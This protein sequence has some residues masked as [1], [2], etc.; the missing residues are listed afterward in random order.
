MSSTAQSPEAREDF[1]AEPVRQRLAARL[2]RHGTG[3]QALAESAAIPGLMMMRLHGCEGMV[4]AIYEPLVALVVQG[5]KRVSFGDETYRYDPQRYFVTPLELPGR[6]VVLEATPERPF[7]SLA[8][9]LDLREIATLV[10]EGVAPPPPAP[11]AG[12]RAMA[13]GAVDAPLLDAFDRLLALLD[14][15]QHAPVLAPLI[16]REITYRLLTGEAGWRLRQIAAVDSQGHQ[17]SRA[18]SL[19]RARFAE[20]LRVEDLAREALMS[21]SSFH[22]HFKALTGMSPLQFQ[23]QLR[24]GE[25]RRLMLVEDLDASTAAYRVGYESASQFSREYARQFGAPPMRDIAALRLRGEGAVAA[26]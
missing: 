24:L 22:H 6:S 2:M 17:V 20:P 1:S 3:L 16:R 15:P 26:P 8:L 5:S 7:L 10:L 11:G 21:A 19:L 12:R 4:C 14:Q 25:A 13:T 18:I 23:K 9:R